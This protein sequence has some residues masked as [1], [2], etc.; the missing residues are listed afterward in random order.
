[1]GCWFC[2]DNPEADRSLI[3]HENAHLYV[4]LDKGPIE[5]FHVLLIPQSHKPS[6]FSL[7]PEE[8]KAFDMCEKQLFEFYEAERRSYIK[9]ERYFRMNDNI[10]HM[11]IHLVSLPQD[12]FRSLE[13]FFLS[14][15]R[16]TKLEFFE[17][18]DGENLEKFLKPED[19]YISLT[20]VDTYTKKEIRRLCILSAN[21]S[22][23]LPPD[24]IRS[25]ICE[26]LDC[27]QRRDWKN[28]IRKE[29]EEN[30]FLIKRFKNYLEK[31]SEN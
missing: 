4:A 15:V 18:Q 25:F 8:K 21:L 2:L 29:D 14:C 6:Y 17:L 19:F 31:S 26:I 5:K 12:K 22:S 11:M 28:C 3:V 20:F 24:F 23:A 7:L 27:R 13:V 16:D 9:C 30:E 1:M 10:N